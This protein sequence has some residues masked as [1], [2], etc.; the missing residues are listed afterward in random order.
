MAELDL[1]LTVGSVALKRYRQRNPHALPSWT[2]LARNLE[3][4]FD[5]N[6]MALGLDSPNPLPDKISYDYELTDLK[7]G[8]GH[9]LDPPP[10]SGVPSATPP[11]ACPPA[12][13]TAPSPRSD[14]MAVPLIRSPAGFWMYDWSRARPA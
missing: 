3:L 9:W 6:K 12:T 7:R 2:R 1:W 8:Y 4:A 10:V 11:I 13:E 5:L 14:I